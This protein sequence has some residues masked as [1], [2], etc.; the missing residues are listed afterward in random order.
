MGVAEIIVKMP[1]QAPADLMNYWLLKSYMSALLTEKDVAPLEVPS[2]VLGFSPR[3]QGSGP[4]APP[5]TARRSALPGFRAPSVWAPW[6]LPAQRRGGRLY[7]EPITDM[8]G[9][10]VLRPRCHRSPSG[11]TLLLWVPSTPRKCLP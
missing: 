3:Q 1:Q 8:G 9:A 2:A 4:S 6:G 7:S 11:E 5:L 10:G